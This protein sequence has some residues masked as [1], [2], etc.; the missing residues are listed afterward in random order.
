M[1]CTISQEEL[2]ALYE[3]QA[4][5]Q[6]DIVVLSNAIA[7]RVTTEEYNSGIGSKADE[8]WVKQQFASIVTQTSK[9][10]TFQFEQARQYTDSAVSSANGYVEQAK[11]YQRFSA[12][13]LE[14][15]QANSPFKA[16][17]GTTK[18]AFLQDGSEVAYIS[19]NKMHITEARVTEKLAIGTE[20]NG[21]FDWVTTS[22]G[23]A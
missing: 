7:A 22:T 4:K 16:K 21:Y 15:G 11:A 9:D 1:E 6:S 18:L 20:A 12:D 19:N 2:D 14:L 23:L 5:A 17:L 8:S 10:V 13:G 3:S